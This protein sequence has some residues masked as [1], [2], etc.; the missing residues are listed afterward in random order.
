MH[1][2]LLLMADGKLSAEEMEQE[3]R[4]LRGMMD[5]SCVEDAEFLRGY[6]LLLDE[7]YMQQAAA[8]RSLSQTNREL[9]ESNER[10]M[11]E[12]QDEFAELRGRLAAH[13]PMK[14]EELPES[15]E[16]LR[17]LFLSLWTHA[18]D[19]PD[20]DKHEWQEMVSRLREFG[21]EIQP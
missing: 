5:L 18:H 15:G 20:Y 1:E 21:I 4:R 12:L 17:P 6:I 9:H 7:A 11:R 2:G 13:V 14:G 19:S 10:I 3:I 8:R 16:R